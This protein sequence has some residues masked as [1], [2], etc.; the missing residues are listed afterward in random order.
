VLMYEVP[1]VALLNAVEEGKAIA[2]EIIQLQLML[3]NGYL[4]KEYVAELYEH[5]L[6]RVDAIQGR[7]EKAQQA[8]RELG[9]ASLGPLPDEAL[10]G[11]AELRV[12]SAELKA[13][14]EPEK[15]QEE[16]VRV[17]ATLV[18]PAMT[19]WFESGVGKYNMV[20]DVEASGRTLATQVL[21]FIALGPRDEGV[22]A[23]GVEMPAPLKTPTRVHQ[24]NPYPS[25]N[26]QTSPLADRYSA[27]SPTYHPTSPAIPY[28]HASLGY[29]PVSPG[30]RAIL[31]TQAYN[32]E[33]SDFE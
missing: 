28:H 21:R 31:R 2:A 3:T 16:M 23:A 20:N 14:K 4:T 6:I 24:L 12:L 10:R 30:T 15:V 8:V 9:P 19:E 5:L 17:N 27:Q 22:N 11:L 32:P 13:D 7:A 26:P 25:Y 29:E 18:G 33:A 1:R